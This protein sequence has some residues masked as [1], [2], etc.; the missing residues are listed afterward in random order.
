[1]GRLQPPCQSNRSGASRNANRSRCEATTPCRRSTASLSS[2]SIVTCSTSARASNVATAEG[3][4]TTPLCSERSTSSLW[5]QCLQS[6]CM[7]LAPLGVGT[8]AL[9][10]GMLRLSL[11]SAAWR[12]EVRGG[13][14]VTRLKR[15]A[16][17]RD[18]ARNPC[19]TQ[20]ATLAGAGDPSLLVAAA[21]PG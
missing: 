12:A 2:P 7:Y 18:L 15:G 5:L 20:T 19:P 16:F 10:I 13:G 11:F 3:N 6:C 8:L 14:R 4:L 17:A 21:W 9:A 1:M